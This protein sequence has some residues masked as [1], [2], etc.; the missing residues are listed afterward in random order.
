MELGIR[1]NDGF[2]AYINGT[3]VAR[4]VPTMGRPSQTNI[5][6]YKTPALARQSPEAPEMYYPIELK[7]EL[8]KAGKN[9]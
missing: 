2:I 3:E 9:I 1:F 4:S 8:L 5:I 7:P 6:N